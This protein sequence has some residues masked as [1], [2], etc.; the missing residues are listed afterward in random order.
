[1]SAEIF[2]NPLVDPRN[3]RVPQPPQKTLGPKNSVNLYA[4]IEDGIKTGIYENAQGDRFVKTKNTFVDSY[5][6]DGKEAITR[7]KWGR[8]AAAVGLTWLVLT[9]LSGG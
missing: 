9:I 3:T 5:L 4:V 8:V 7:T 6:A 1:M 2:Y